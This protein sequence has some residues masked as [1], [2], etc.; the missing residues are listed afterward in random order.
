M[1]AYAVT[2]TGGVDYVVVASTEPAAKL[3]VLAY[4][5]KL[6][7]EDLDSEGPPDIFSSVEIP[8]GRSGGYHLCDLSDRVLL[9]EDK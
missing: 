8:R 7:L 3:L 9:V 6:G 2:D 4:N 5:R 1:P